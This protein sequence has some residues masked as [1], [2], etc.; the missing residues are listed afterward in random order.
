M[1]HIESNTC[2]TF[3]GI[4]SSMTLF[5]RIHHVRFSRSGY[6]YDIFSKVVVQRLFTYSAL[7]TYS[8]IIHTLGSTWETCGY[9]YTCFCN[10]STCIAIEIGGIMSHIILLLLS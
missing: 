5:K 2:I 9:L 3:E 4:P 7:S 6:R 8:A 1:S 10:T